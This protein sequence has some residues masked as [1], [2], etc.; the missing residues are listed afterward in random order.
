MNLH[1]FA[2][3]LAVWLLVRPS[4]ATAQLYKCVSNG[5]VTYQGAP[6]PA[7]EAGRQPTVDELNA[8]RKKKLA[9]SAEV[10]PKPSP[11][12]GGVASPPP[13]AP[14][15]GKPVAAAPRFKC[16]G[17]RYCAQMTS[18]AE[19]TYFLAHCPGVRMDGDGDGVPCESQ[20]CVK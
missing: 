9:Q 16:D 3:A 8:Q 12:I 5:A 11:A 15:A 10:S 13:Q 14:P 18:C 17:R 19:A 6:C 1:L 2:L 20:W 7:G 4:S